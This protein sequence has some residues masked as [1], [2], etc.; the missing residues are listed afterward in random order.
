MWPTTPVKTMVANFLY[1]IYV[2]Q[3]R[4]PDK[5]KAGFIDTGG[6][7]VIHAKYDDARSFKEGFAAVQ[8]NGRWGLIDGE[9]NLVIPCIHEGIGLVV[10]EG[11]IRYSAG[12]R[13]GVLDTAGDVVVTPQ[14]WSVSNFSDGA[15]YIWDGKHYG[16]INRNGE[17]FIPPFFED[18]RE[19][20]DGLAPVKLGEKWGYIDKKATFVIEPRFDFALPFWE[21]L[22]RVAVG[23]RRGPY[24]YI[25]RSGSF[26][27]R[28]RFGEA[29]DFKEGLAAASPNPRGA[30]G[31]IDKSGEFVIAPRFQYAMPFVEGMVA[32]SEKGERFKHFIR[33]TGERAFPGEYLSADSFHNQR[34][35]VST[36]KT[37]GYIDTQGRTVWE[38][39]Y[40][41]R[42]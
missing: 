33:K 22:A 27:I 15:A 36:M 40:V 41:S 20:R 17:E 25:D 34:C 18:A 3:G 23:G 32:V 28:P 19:F 38:G 37:T 16:F 1:P 5:Y 42:A 39:A 7:V 6:R 14:Y 12:N 35:L 21:D 10:T 24:G 9:E 4:N 11:R 8:L 31:Y 30:K 2:R 13:H 29:L 26:V